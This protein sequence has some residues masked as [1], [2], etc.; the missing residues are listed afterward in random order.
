VPDPSGAQAIPPYRVHLQDDALNLFQAEI[1]DCPEDESAVAKAL[2]LLIAAPIYVTG[3][4]VWQ[5]DRCVFK[6]R[7]MVRR[8][9][10]DSAPA[11]EPSAGSQRRSVLVC[12]DNKD[13]LDIMRRICIGLDYSVRTVNTG[14]YFMAACVQAMPDCI[15]L[16]LNLPDIGGLSL[17]QWLGDVGCSSRIIVTSGTTDEAQFA[18]VSRLAQRG[19]SIAILRKPFQMSNL[20]YLLREGETLDRPG[21]AEQGRSGKAGAT[22][23]LE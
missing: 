19:L 7:S 17:L 22:P 5:Q 8:D 2:A 10:P 18:K 15:V 13:V 3:F 11:Q 9:A 14:W 4:E 20:V 1:L 16:D 12:D 23:S 21:R 6:L